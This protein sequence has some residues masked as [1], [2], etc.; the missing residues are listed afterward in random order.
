[1]DRD[2]DEFK[3][4]LR[5]GKNVIY[6][7]GYSWEC[8]VWSPEVTEEVFFT[9]CPVSRAAIEV[10]PTVEELFADLR[11]KLRRLVYADIV[12][13]MHGGS[14]L[15]RNKPDAVFRIGPSGAPILRVE[16]LR[17]LL[18]D[19]RQNRTEAIRASRKILFDAHCNCVGHIIT[20]FCYRIVCY[21]LK[22]V[23][24][25]GRIARHPI[26]ALAIEKFG[27]LCREGRLAAIAAYYRA[28]FGVVQ[29]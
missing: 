1:M 13:A 29:I 18:R 20:A 21:L 26:E 7:R 24:Y 8:D 23:S 6:T 17:K 2:H 14:L 25:T 5:T 4:I 27:Q 11:R 12:L 15:P 3:G 10:R 22:Q 16:E 9:I 28:A 19:H